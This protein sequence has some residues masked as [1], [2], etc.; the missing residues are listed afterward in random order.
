MAI[1]FFDDSCQARVSWCVLFGN[2]L[3]PN[4]NN[5]A[6]FWRLSAE[7]L[8]FSFSSS[9]Y[10][11]FYQI[12]VRMRLYFVVLEAVLVLNVMKILMS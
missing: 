9:L 3:L 12:A 1:R 4:Q 7:K 6:Y 10:V 2:L 5:L 11:N 8:K